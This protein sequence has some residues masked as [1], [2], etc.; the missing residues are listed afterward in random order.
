MTLCGKGYYIWQIPRCDEGIPSA[1]A[2]RAVEADLSY[3]MIKIADG[4]NWPYNFDYDKGVDLVPP[5]MNA[6]REVGLQV[7]GWHYVKGDNPAGE[8][9]LAVERTLSLG[10]DGYVIDAEAEYKNKKKAK[11]AARYV[12]DLRAGMPDVPIALST[13]R[14]PRVHPELPYSEF[15]EKCDYAM[16]QVYFEKAHNPEEQLERSVEQY[17]ALDHA[18]PVIPTAPAYQAG[19]WRPTVDEITRFFQKA[20]DMGLSSANA[21]SWDYAT[22]P[23]HID[24]WQAIA[25]FDWPPLAPKPDVSEHLIGR[26]NQHEPAYVA[27]LYRDNAAHVTGART[28]LGRGAIAQWYNVLFTDLL[29]NAQFELTGRTSNG[30]S[31]RFSWTASSEKG[32]VLN[33]N[34]TLGI[35]DGEIQYHYT[36]FTI[37]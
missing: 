17:M 8:A 13:Y 3:V 33:G 14:Y 18:R 12:A 32:M 27:E 37:T 7:W 6:L 29:P 34:D 21:W 23:S 25:D 11:A 9:Q 22:R 5:V 20:K 24:L 15:L 30:N 28:I 10:L 16:P 31:R 2:A 19:S 35:L 36:Y 4:P 26:M 1:I